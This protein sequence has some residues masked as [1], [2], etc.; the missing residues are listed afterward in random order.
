M[1]IL[2]FLNKIEYRILVFTV[3]FVSLF[4]LSF[5]GLGTISVVSLW[6]LARWLPIMLL[7]VFFVATRTAF[8]D[9]KTSASIWQKNMNIGLV[10]LGVML[11]SGLLFLMSLSV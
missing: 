9:I 4:T 8:L 10:V 6:I 3:V 1:K 11:C 2:K 5:A 7:I